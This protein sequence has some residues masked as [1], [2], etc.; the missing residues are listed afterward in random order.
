MSQDN[1]ENR[2]KAGRLFKVFISFYMYFR[3]F[4]RKSFR[5]LEPEFHLISSFWPP[6]PSSIDAACEVISKDTVFI[7]KGNYFIIIYL[8]C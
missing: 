1:E 2:P 6:L 8:T 4:W 7:F 5:R 3:H